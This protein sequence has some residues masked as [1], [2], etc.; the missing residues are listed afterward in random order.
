MNLNK[1]IFKIFN[2]PQHASHEIIFKP[3]FYNFIIWALGS[4]LREIG[5]YIYLEQW[6][7]W[8]GTSRRMLGDTEVSSN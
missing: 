4:M 6:E 8:W 2:L 5:I 7:A 1:P 3:H